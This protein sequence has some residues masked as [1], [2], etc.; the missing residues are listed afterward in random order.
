MSSE[1]RSSSSPPRPPT[2]STA[3]SSSSTAG[4]RRS[5]SARDR[6]RHRRDVHG[7]RPARLRRHA[8]DEEGALDSRR[9]RPRRRPGHSSSSLDE[10]G[11]AP[12]TSPRSCTRRP[13]RRTPSSRAGAS[14]CCLLTTAGFRDVLEMRRLRIPVIYDLQYEKPPPLVPRRRRYE[15][16][17]RIGPRGEDWAALDE[18]AV[19]AAAEQARAEGVE[20]VAICFLHAYANPAHERR[21]AAIV[22][23]VVGDDVYV[24]RSSDILPEIREYERTSTAVVNAYVGPVVE[25]YLGS[26]EATPG[27]SRDLGAAA[28]HAVER[29]A[30]ERR[31]GDAQAGAPRRVGA[32][33]RCRR[34]RLPR[35][36]D[37]PPERDLA[38]HGRHDREGRDPRGRPA[39]EDVGVRGRRRHQPE[40]PAGQGRR[41]RD[42]AAVHRRLRDRRGRRQH[43][44][45]GRVRDAPRRPRERRLG[46]RAR[47]LRPRRRPSRRSPTPSS[48]S[49]TSTPST[50]PAAPSSSTRDAAGARDRAPSRRRSG[51]SPIEAAHGV[52]QLAVATMTRAV[53]AVSTYRGRDPRDFV[54]C[55][56]G[57]NG[58]VVAVE[59]AR[60]LQMRRVLVPPAPGRLQRG[61]A[62][63]SPTSSTSSCG[64]SLPAAQPPPRSCCSAGFRRRW[65]TEAARRA[66]GRR[67][68]ARRNRRLPLR[69]HPL[70]RPGVRADAADRGRSPRPRTDRGRLRRRAPP[71]VRAR[72]RGRGDRHRQPAADGAGDRERRSATTR[73]PASRRSARPS[74]R[75]APTSAR[76]TEHSTSGRHP[77]GAAR[78]AAAG[79]PADRRGV[80]FRPASSRRAAG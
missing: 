45:R 34:L 76:P 10:A 2:S 18:G 75:A 61:R 39:G 68:V 51:T 24:T 21:A 64:R 13:S 22:R 25:R 54:L 40:Q 1:A 36:R 49:A 28:D 43:R 6:R 35:P 50:W 8:A 14:S 79:G 60:A 27:R 29:R 20:A 73:S 38:R 26:L 65:R 44:H 5:S 16:P 33:R 78:L 70:R 56:F 77:R 11:A 63:S 53:K 19:R 80:R 7:R 62:C 23:E 17:E 72:L 4:S 47:L 12:A 9:L 74:G 57:G 37:R 66:R 52:F 48:C 30:D 67:R 41:L 46:S 42:Q 15:I 71:D 58:P 3:R 55:G 32:G 59:I 69:R 31:R